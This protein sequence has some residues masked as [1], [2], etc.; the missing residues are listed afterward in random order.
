M[1]EKFEHEDIR[2]ITR[3]IAELRDACGYTPEEFANELGIPAEKY[4]AYEEN[5]STIPVS[6]I[7]NIAKLCG[8]ELSEI[9]TGVSA[10]LHTLQIVRSGEATGI[11]RYPGYH[12]EDLAHRFAGKTMQPMLVN[13]YPDDE[14]PAMAKH[15]GQEFNYVLEGTVDLYWNGKVY[16]LNKDDSVYFNPTYDHAQHC[17]GD[18]PAKFI[19]IIAE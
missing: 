16:T 19:T 5:A 17:H 1:A 13:L 6:L 2:E 18:A 3:R 14:I 12:M 9:M 4:I 8:V 15:G 10:K 7:C 11:E